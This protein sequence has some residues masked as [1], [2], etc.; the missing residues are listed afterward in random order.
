MLKVLA[1]AAAQSV[2]CSHKVDCFLAELAPGSGGE[3]MR[4][5]G[6]AH[7]LAIHPIL[8][9]WHQCHQ[10]SAVEAQ[11]GVTQAMACHDPQPT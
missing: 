9:A 7:F 3:T 10:A 2:H 5:Y 4:I 1:M 8:C 11:I 6:P